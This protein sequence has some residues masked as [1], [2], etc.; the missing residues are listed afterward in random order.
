M[1]KY[2]L[3]VVIPSYKD[4]Y[5][6]NTIDSLLSNSELGDKL[7]IVAV[8]DGYWPEFELRNDPRVKYVHLGKNRGMRGAINAGVGVAR[9]EF[10][11]RLDEHCMFAKGYDK[12]L[13][14]ACQ[15]NWMMTATRYFLDPVK[16]ERMDL[17]P[18]RCEKLVIQGGKKFAGMRWPERDEEFKD[19]PLV[20]TMAM[21]GSMWIVPRKWFNEV[22]VE[23]E[24]EGY[25][26]AYQDSHEA[27]FK[28]WKKGGKLILNKNTWFA[29]KHRSFN[30]THQE[31]TKENPWKREQSWAYALKVWG[32]YYEQEIK[33]KWKI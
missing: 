30:R 1:D 10:I 18:V 31:G 26:P 19:E 5:L 17:P 7:E 11:M 12:T 23:L 3:S 6:I 33:P 32:D 24:A 8:L 28:T 21:Q 9:G 25:G 16:W 13:T 20:E 22:I 29:H 15:P 27:V 2:K 14:D 4:P